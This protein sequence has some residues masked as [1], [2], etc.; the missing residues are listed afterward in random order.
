MNAILNAVH[1]YAI[2]N[3]GELPDGITGTVAEI[4]KST[5]ASTTC[6]TEG[7]VHLGTDVLVPRYVVGIPVD[8]L[9]PDA[10]NG[11][12]YWISTTASSRVLVDA[13]LA[14]ETADI[15]VER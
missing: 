14:Q 13:P 1:Q 12:G 4:C 10:G 11:T 9:A 3:Q 2:E 6:A 15:S 7:L 8:P 5:V